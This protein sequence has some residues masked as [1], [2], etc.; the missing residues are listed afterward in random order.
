MVLCST[1][2]KYPGLLDGIQTDIDPFLEALKPFERKEN[3]DSNLLEILFRKLMTDLVATNINKHNFYVAPEV[4][5]NEMQRGEF[6]LP[7]GYFL[8]PHFFLFKVTKH[9]KY[10]SAPDPDFKIRFPEKKNEY[11]LAMEN[12][13]GSMLVNRAFYEIQYKKKGGQNFMSKNN[14]RTFP[15]YRIP[16]HLQ[17][18]S[19]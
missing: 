8:V 5:Q 17:Q 15:N 14:Y 1:Y 7:D 16:P 2:S 6:N 19:N 12:F 18:S 13:I 4:V 11:V 9:Q 3:F 10:I